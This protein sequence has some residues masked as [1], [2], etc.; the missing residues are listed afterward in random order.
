MVNHIGGKRVLFATDSTLALV[1][2]AW[3]SGM[4]LR[5]VQTF[6]SVMPHWAGPTAGTRSLKRDSGRGLK[7]LG[8]VLAG[9]YFSLTQSHSTQPT[10]PVFLTLT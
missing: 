6:N 9:T 8:V 2:S 7:A 5:D 10:F 3:W 4:L 1:S